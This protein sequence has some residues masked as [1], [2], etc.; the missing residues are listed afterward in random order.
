M[1]TITSKR[2]KEL[3][4]RA[5]EERGIPSVQLMENA[6]RAVAHELLKHVKAN[7]ESA[8]GVTVLCGSGNNGGDG[9]AAARFLLDEGVKVRVFLAGDREKMTAET[10]EMERR[11]Q[12]CGGILETFAPDNLWFEECRY[13]ID[14]LIGIGLHEQVRGAA[15]EAIQV[16]EKYGNGRTLAVDVPSGV[17]ADT[18]KNLGNHCR[19]LATVT[20][21]LPKPGHF[22]GHGGVACGKL[23]V[24]DIGIPTDLVD[25][26]DYPIV[27]VDAELV[28]SFLPERDPAAHKGDFGKVH[29][30]GGSTGYAGAPVLAAKAALRS[31]AGLV[32]LS[33]PADIYQIVAVKCDEAMPAPVTDDDRGLIREDAAMELFQTL[34]GK[35]ACLIGPGLGRSGGLES[36]VCNLAAAV[37]LPMILDAD[38]INAIVAHMDVLELRRSFPTILTPHDAEFQRLGGDLSGGDRIGAALKLAK[39]C[40]CVVVLKGHGTVI[41]IPNGKAFL[42]TTGNCGMATGGSGDALAGMILSLIGQGI[43]PVKATVAA[44]WLH[45]RAGDLAAE[46]KGVYGMLPTDLI[47]Q[48]PYAI[49][50]VTKLK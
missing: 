38:G 19:C 14:A 36:L 20:F 11:L 40:G 3:D 16:L 6:G 10:A 32:S 24:A 8:A 45:G 39:A 49:Q 29:I 44:V 33:V 25:S 28:S 30:V 47:E 18:G 23:V 34:A 42:N 13:F 35:N 41:A 21:T 7:G 2:M 12:E 37:N 17:D 15:A 1:R 50:E 46:D 4:R 22:V 43:H 48:I 5:I 9:I 26:L 31:G 27:A